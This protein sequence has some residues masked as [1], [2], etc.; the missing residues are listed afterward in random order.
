MM[1]VFLHLYLY[2]RDPALL[3]ERF[4]VVGAEGQERWDKLWILCFLLGSGVWLGAMAVDAARM[5]WSPG[6][7]LA[8][9]VA[10]GV[11]LGAAFFFIFRA[12]KD[13]PYLAPSVR[14]QKD[15]GQTVM[16]G[17][18]YKVVRH[19]MYLGAMAMYIGGPLLLGSLGGIAAGVL[20]GG[21]FGYRIVREERMLM[22]ELEGYVDYQKA[23]RWRLIPWIW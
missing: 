1:M 2:F 7:P 22:A 9:K 19:P 11:G 18:V 21:V 5:G 23:V 3:K 17:G 4:Q 12:F 8:V 10:G 14:M 20:M 15:R 16:T 6:F 13:N